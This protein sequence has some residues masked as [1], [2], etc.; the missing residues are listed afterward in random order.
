M[1]IL[2][3][4]ALIWKIIHRGE[5][6]YISSGETRSKTVASQERKRSTAQ[7]VSLQ[8]CFSRKTTQVIHNQQNGISVPGDWF[9]YSDDD[10]AWQCLPSGYDCLYANPARLARTIY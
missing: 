1:K 7:I 10:A 8:V 2:F 4:Q 3:C 5:S 6:A 9:L